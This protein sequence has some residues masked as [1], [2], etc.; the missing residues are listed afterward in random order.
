MKEERLVEQ[1]RERIVRSK[2]KHKLLLWLLANYPYPA[3]FTIPT[4]IVATGNDNLRNVA[5]WPAEYVAANL[6]ETLSPG[7]Y[8]MREDAASITVEVERRLV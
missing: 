3:E 1:C 6:F 7:T 2:Q 5:Q 4:L 8:R